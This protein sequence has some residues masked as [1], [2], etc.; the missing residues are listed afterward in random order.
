MHTV[1]DVERAGHLPGV[2][3]L[4]VLASLGQHHE[5]L[6]VSVPKEVCLA[7]APTAA[8]GVDVRR[9]HLAQLLFVVE[10]EHCVAAA[11]K[12]KLAAYALFSD[13][14]DILGAV[15]LVLHSDQFLGVWVSG[16]RLQ[17]YV[18]IV[19]HNLRVFLLD[20]IIAYQVYRQ[21][22]VTRFVLAEA[23]RP[24]AIDVAYN[25]AADRLRTEIDASDACQIRKVFEMQVLAVLLAQVPLEL[26]AVRPPQVVSDPHVDH[27]GTVATR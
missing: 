16:D 20:A 18:A 27:F 7:E 13:F 24:R 17:H 25:H 4:D 9:D 2:V 8:D 10:V 22:V 5:F 12:E 21:V 19:L 26:A 11:L 1:V 15:Q 3:S 23:L 14:V 6:E